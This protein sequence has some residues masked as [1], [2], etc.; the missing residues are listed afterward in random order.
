[1]V[2]TYIAMKVMPHKKHIIWVQD[3][4]DENDYKLL[5]SVD[6]NYKFIRFK[7]EVAKMLYEIAYKHADLILTQARYYISKI[8]KLYR[9]NPE[10]VGY[11]S[12]PVER[13]ANEATTKSCKG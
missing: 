3:P 9:V 10:R 6:S 4:F 1:M 5:S 11:L 2:E 8:A 7:F 13:V 12:N